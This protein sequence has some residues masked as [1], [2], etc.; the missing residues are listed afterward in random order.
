MSILITTQPIPNQTLTT[1]LEG[2]RYRLTLK[3]AGSILAV[4][5]DRDNV[6]LLTGI[7]AVAGTP[8]IPYNHLF[9]NLGNFV[10]ETFDAELPNWQQLGDTQR[11]IYFT[12]EEIRGFRGN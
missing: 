2:N 4:N 11:L 10:F 8:L 9:P 7:R 12:A 1:S 6:R 3:A 5:I